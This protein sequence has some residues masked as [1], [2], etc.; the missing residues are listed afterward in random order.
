V[1]GFLNH[2][3]NTLAETTS[4]VNLTQ[5]LLRQIRGSTH[6]VVSDF[7]RLLLEH[8]KTPRSIHRLTRKTVCNRGMKAWPEARRR[9]APIVH[10]EIGNRPQATTIEPNLLRGLLYKQSGPGGELLWRAELLKTVNSAAGIKR[11]IKR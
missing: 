4:V 11:E 8:P 9:S 3:F 2:P 6:P 10:G 7:G 5:V 1:A